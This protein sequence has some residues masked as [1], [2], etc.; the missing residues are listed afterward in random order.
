MYR[1]AKDAGRLRKSDGRPEAFEVDLPSQLLMGMFRELRK[2]NHVY[3]GGKKKKFQDKGWPTPKTAADI[4]KAQAAEQGYDDLMAEIVFAEPDEFDRIVAE[5][6]GDVIR[7][8]IE[9]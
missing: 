8:E 4:V 1:A 2:L 7:H 5:H 3:Y 9:Q 6:G